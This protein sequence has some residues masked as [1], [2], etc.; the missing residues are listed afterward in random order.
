MTRGEIWWVEVDDRRLVLVLS[1]TDDDVRA[2]MIV[3]PAERLV[4]GIVEEVRLG[5]DDGLQSAGVVR[6][7]FPSET[8]IPCNWLVTLP[9]HVMTERVGALAA[10]KLTEVDSLLQRAGLDLV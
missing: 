10:D 9:R 2:I 7:A 6:V 3:P 4:D 5:A 1:T 8:F